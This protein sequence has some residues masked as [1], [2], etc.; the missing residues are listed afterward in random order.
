MQPFKLATGTYLTPLP[1]LKSQR[2]CGIGNCA[3]DPQDLYPLLQAWKRENTDPTI[4]PRT[5]LQGAAR[6]RGNRSSGRSQLL[7]DEAELLFAGLRTSYCWAV[8]DSFVGSD[9]RD[10]NQILR[11]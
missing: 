3:I 10:E 2:L 7:A 9:A 8:T 5:P 1:T 11:S 4:L 6:P